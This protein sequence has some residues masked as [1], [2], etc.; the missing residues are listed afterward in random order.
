MRL[1][2]I[3]SAADDE[4]VVVAP[5]VEQSRLEWLTNDEGEAREQA[6]AVGETD[7]R[8][9][10]R[11]RREVEVKPDSPSRAVL[12]AIAEHHPDRIVAVVR[13]GEDATWLE[14]GDQHTGT[15]RRRP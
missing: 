2:Q 1:S 3:T 9:S 12:D 15:P 10:A 5:A 14:D 11:R 8:R 6:Q 13:K 7:R 4:L